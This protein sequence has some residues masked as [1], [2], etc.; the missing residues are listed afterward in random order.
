LDW[1]RQLLALAG[2]A[3]AGGALAATAISFQAGQQHIRPA[4]YCG[5]G[6]GAT[7]VDPRLSSR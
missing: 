2:I 1:W 5:N 3:P 4:E 7:A 6:S